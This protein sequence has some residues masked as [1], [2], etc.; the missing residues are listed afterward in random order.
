MAGANGQGGGGA[1]YKPKT[2]SGVPYDEC[3]WGIQKM[4]RRGKEKEALILAHELCAS[5]YPAAVARRLMI[6]ACEDVGLANPAV[7]A[8]VHTFCM[9]YL[10]LKK[11]ARAGMDPEPLA[12]YMSIML[13]AR[14]EECDLVFNTRPTHRVALVEKCYIERVLERRLAK[15]QPISS[16]R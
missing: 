9:G 2:L 4:I 6:I 1:P 3:I 16:Q 7:V 8:Q 13:L 12:I 14:S 10:V 15:P 5:G 11:D